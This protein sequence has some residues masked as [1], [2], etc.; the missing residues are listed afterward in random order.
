MDRDEIIK[1]VELFTNV[2]TGNHISKDDAIHP[3]YAGIKIFDTPILAFGAAND[4]LYTK[5][6]S[7]DVIGEN[8]MAPIEWLQDAKTV[9]SFFL[10]Y[11]SYIKESNSKNYKWPS[12]EWLHG[13][14]EGHIFVQ[15]L[16]QFIEKMLIKAGYKAVVPSMN[17]SFE[18]KRIETDENI[19][20]ITNWS[21][22][23]VAFACGLGTFG[24]SK[25][26]ITKKGICGRFGSIITDLELPSDER[27]YKEIY[28]YCNM[29][30][31]CIAHCPANAISLDKGKNSSLC[32]KFLDK[33]REKHAPRYGCGKCQV[34]VPCES[35]IP[36]K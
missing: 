3:K 22:R 31:V 30:G 21:E 29:C 6:K 28:E 18:L 7:P 17:D 10:P 35:G 15:N 12:N 2:S 27:N 11:I 25:G 9:I 8:F 36:I 5:F 26:L 33:V 4:E 16:M 24:L 20:Y 23:H 32:S 1:S 14:Y 19:K 34:N 13:R